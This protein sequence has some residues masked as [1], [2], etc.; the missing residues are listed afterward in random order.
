MINILVS[1]GF[2]DGDP[3]K[4]PKTEGFARLLGKEV[5]KQGHV[6]LSACLSS[7]DR[8]VAEGAKEELEEQELRRRYRKSHYRLCISQPGA[9][10]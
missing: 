4:S 3:E 5:I 10:S 1:G 2:K 7:F 8:V 6:L 9:F